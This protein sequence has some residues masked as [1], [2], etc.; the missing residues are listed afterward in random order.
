MT[1]ADTEEA[2]RRG[3]DTG[4]IQLT[5]ATK[6][7]EAGLN[8]YLLSAQMSAPIPSWPNAHIDINLVSLSAFYA[9]F[10]RQLE[11]VECRREHH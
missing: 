4:P 8:S 5:Q 11:E 2:P 1:A 3:A 6:E 9:N 7:K 10:S